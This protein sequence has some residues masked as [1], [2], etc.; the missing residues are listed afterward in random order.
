MKPGLV[1]RLGRTLVS[2]FTPVPGS[3]LQRKCACGGTPGPTGECEACRKK[4]LQRKS[5]N[6]ANETQNE[7][8]VP[9]IVHEVLRSPG[10]PLD[11]ETRAF[12]APRFGHDFGN[13]HVHTDAKAAESAR[14]VNSQ[15]YTVGRDVVFASGLYR[16]HSAEGRSLLIH[17]LAHVVQQLGT[18]HGSGNLEIGEVNSSAEREADEAARTHVNDAP[19]KISRQAGRL[20]LQ[21]KW[22][23]ARAGWGALIGGGIGTIVGGLASLALGPAALLVGLGAG[24]V[25]G[26]LIGGL[27]GSEE[28]KKQQKPQALPPAPG[29]T[30]V[31]DGMITSGLREGVTMLQTTI[32]A[33]TGLSPKVSPGDRSRRAADAMKRFF[34]SDDS[35]VVNHVSRRLVQIRDFMSALTQKRAAPPPVKQPPD[36]NFVAPTEC[37]TVAMDDDCGRAIAYV[38]EVRPGHTEREGMVFCPRF[39]ENT[40]AKNDQER[41]GIVI[42]EA[43]HSLKGGENI[44]DRGYA[45]LRFFPDLSTEDALTNADSYRVFVLQVA[46]DSEQRVGHIFTDIVEDC[47]PD[48]PKVGQALGR[49]QRWL[50]IAE[51]VVHDKRPAWR[52]LDYWVKLRNKYLGGESQDLVDAAAKS[53]DTIAGMLGMFVSARCHPKADATCPSGIA[54]ASSPGSLGPEIQLCPDWLAEKDPDR[55]A[56]LLFAEMLGSTGITAAQARLNHAEMARQL[57]ADLGQAPSLEKI[58]APFETPAASGPSKAAPPATKP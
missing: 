43:A 27:T 21:R 16:P 3:V 22:D 48:E 13:V 6:A 24:L 50:G 14:A 34:K 11:R 57:F 52:A 36:P 2:P 40:T 56:I 58:L 15:A 28:Q 31:N 54:T 17:E 26:G 46:G 42:H 7:S 53:Y 51:R 19:A 33:L 41:G 29:C 38:P 39:F 47:G 35:R 44:G 5:S 23:W 45:D 10:Q 18:H 20:S 1:P 49:I 9:P 32:P 55:Q 37:H 30:P 25:A 4:R 8:E 12:M